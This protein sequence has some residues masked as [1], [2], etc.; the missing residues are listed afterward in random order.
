M[1]YSSD[2][3]FKRHVMPHRTLFPAPSEKRV[4][5]PS[6]SS[7]ALAASL[8]SHHLFPSPSLV[9]ASPRRFSLRPQMNG[10]EGLEVNLE[11]GSATTSADTDMPIDEVEEEELEA[12]SEDPTGK[13]KCKKRTTSIVVLH[14]DKLPLSEDKRLREKCK[15]YGSVYLADSKNWIGSMQRHLVVCQHKDT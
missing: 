3:N 4:S 12:I 11:S 5:L 13:A 9:A 1:S 8:Y 7:L 15:E 2:L 6:H 14:F 10:I